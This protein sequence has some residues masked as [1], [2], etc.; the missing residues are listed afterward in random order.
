LYDHLGKKIRK[1]IKIS[2]LNF[3]SKKKVELGVNFKDSAGRYDGFERKNLKQ[4]F[5]H[6]YFDIF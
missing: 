3:F 1:I 5:M 6:F 2:I 4:I